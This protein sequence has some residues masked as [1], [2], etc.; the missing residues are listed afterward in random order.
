MGRWAV[1]DEGLWMPEEEDLLE[2]E[3][4]ELDISTGATPC[5]HSQTPPV[6]QVGKSPASAVSVQ[7][8]RLAREARA[9]IQALLQ[10]H[11]SNAAKAANHGAAEAALAATSREARLTQL[12]GLCAQAMRDVKTTLETAEQEQKELRASFARE[13]ADL[14]MRAERLRAEQATEWSAFAAS[15]EEGATGDELTIT[16]S[17]KTMF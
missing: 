10:M 4:P 15:I 3:F 16:C 5:S 12:Y 17:D 2:D 11:S 8:E 6:I 13:R 1:L 9:D 7:Q 14:I